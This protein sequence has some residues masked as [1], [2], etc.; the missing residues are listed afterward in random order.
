MYHYVRP[1]SEEYP[2]LNSLDIGIFRRQLDYFEKEYGFL[3]KAEY[4]NAVK[5]G[6]NPKGVVLTF[7]DGFRDH[8]DYVLPELKKRGLWGIFYISTGVYQKN[9]LLGVHRVH[10]LKGKYGAKLILDEVLKNID[11]SMLDHNTIKEFDKEIYA[12]INYEEDEKKLRR[13]LNFYISY[14][15]RDNILNK[16]M[17]KFFNEDKLFKDVYLSVNEIKQLILSENI[18]GSHT[19]SHSVLSRLTY[20]EQYNEIE[21]S[22]NFIDSIVNQEYKSFCYPFGYESSYNGDT[23]KAL[24]LLNV[25]DACIFDNKIQGDEVKKYELSRTDCNKFLEV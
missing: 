7:D 22:F 16:L 6:I 19:V 18:V 1:F 13:L 20:Q 12:G 9:K 10:Y 5:K 4:Q 3:S 14:K 24:S 17:K 2:N 21:N 11:S 23:L 15:Y 25:D 8:I